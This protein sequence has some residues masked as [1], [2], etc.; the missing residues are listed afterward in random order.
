MRSL[1][2]SSVVQVR[3]FLL[4][5]IRT[6]DNSNFLCADE[7]KVD[8]QNLENAEETI[9]RSELSSALAPYENEADKFVH[10][11]KTKVD[12]VDNEF[13]IVCDLAT[14]ILKY[15]KQMVDNIAIIRKVA[16]IFLTS[17]SANLSY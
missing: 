9:E 8:E 13:Y 10:F 3:I 14:D 5:D 16:Y 7:N 11:K 2:H 17:E 12:S 6:S 15:E 1:N 4:S